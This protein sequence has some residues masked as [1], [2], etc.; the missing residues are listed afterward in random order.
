[1]SAAVRVAVD[2]MGGDFGPGV[3]VPACLSLLKKE[4]DL[5]I[6]LVGDSLYLEP[7]LIDLPAGIADRLSVVHASDVVTM[8]DKPSAVIR[9][10]KDSSMRKAIELVKQ[11]QADAC[12][13]AGNTGALM[14]LGSFLLGR[15]PGVARPAICSAL[16]SRQGSSF[17]L[18]LGANIDGSA[19][20]LH[21]HAVMG[22]LLAKGIKGMAQP[23]VALLNIG[24]EANKGLE[25]VREAATRLQNDDSIHF[26]G[27]VE[28]SDIYL[29]AADVIV[30]D[31]FVGNVALKASEGVAKLIAHRLKNS[32]SNSGFARAMGV[33]AY[34]V[35]RRLYSSI[36]PRRFNGA[37]FL[38]LNGVL[39]KSHGNSDKLAFETAV[40]HA[41]KMVRQK[42]IDNMNAELLA[43]DSAS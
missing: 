21:Q 15:L 17:M 23:K 14:A 33:L 36:D 42:I 24:E 39:V 1:M 6:V 34:P 32:F 7:Y 8:E 22:S 19:D 11:G 10:K 40:Y 35:L 28:G 2:A 5:A 26:I 38:G 43:R 18:D 20:I 31:G 16:P 29:N 4:P 9:S 12:V 41:V 30:C 37:S 25:Q 3:T 13:S 27:F